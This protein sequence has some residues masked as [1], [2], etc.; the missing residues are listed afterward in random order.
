MTGA[1][2]VADPAT[3]EVSTLRFGPS[4]GIPNH[5]DLPVVLIRGAVDGSAEAIMALC[6]QN[7]W[8]G[9]WCWSVY[10]FHHW[11]LDSHEALTVATGWAE[12]RLGGPDG[13]LVR[14]EA[15][16]VAIL[17]AGTGHKREAASD[18]FAICGA[19]PPGQERPAIWR[20]SAVPPET[21][22]D[23]LRDVPLPGTDPI[24]GAGGP[25]IAAWTD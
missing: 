23:H 16:D 3:V 10:D 17:P 24:Y 2:K 18:D 15:G 14:V 12:L 1:A 6:Q 20:E 7:G 21:T 25:L 19:Y 4:K 9:C 5:P 8:G 11:H 13:E 22:H